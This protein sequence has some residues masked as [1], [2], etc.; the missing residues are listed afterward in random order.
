MK[1]YIFIIM[2]YIFKERIN[3]IS[4]NCVYMIKNIINNKVYIGSTIKLKKRIIVHFNL[5]KNKKHT[6][7]KL[8]RSWNKHGEESFRFYIIEENIDIKFLIER[9]QFYI[10]TYNSVKNGFNLTPKAGTTLGNKWSEESKLTYSKMKK[11]LELGEPVVQY[12][13]NGNKL[14]EF[15]NMKIAAL[16]IGLKNSSNIGMVCRKERKTFGGFIWEYKDL[17][18]Q[19]KYGV[20]EFNNNFKL[21]CPHCKS[22][23]LKRAGFVYLKNIKKQNY[24]CKNCLKRF[25]ETT[26]NGFSPNSDIEKHKQIRELKDKLTYKEIS[27]IVNL[28]PNSVY[29]IIKKYVIN[30]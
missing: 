18:K 16:T 14:N 1:F 8:Q 10:D 30:E 5:L 22:I 4:Y 13:L 11:S 29:R 21:E 25:S 23:N 9:E 26:N 28:H 3:V 19:K 15:K 6:S 7:I 20:H 27:E 2:E 17:E 12:D 24:K